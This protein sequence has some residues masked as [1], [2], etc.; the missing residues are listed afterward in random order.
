MRPDQNMKRALIAFVVFS[1]TVAVEG[2]PS[3]YLPRILYAAPGLELN[4][5]YGNVFDSVV[6]QSY[7]FQSFCE[8]GRA[9]TRRWCFTPTAADAGRQ[10]EL[11]VNAWNDTGL[12]AAAT[13]TVLVATLPS[14]ADRPMTMALL[15]DSLTNA[16]YQDHLFRVMRNAGY[17]SYR[18]I[19][20]RKSSAKDGVCYD[21]YGGYTFESFLTRY[22]LSEEEVNNI[23]DAAEREQ[24][25]TLGLSVKVVSERQRQLLRSPLVRIE[26][27]KKIVDVQRWLDRINGGRAPDIILIELG[28]NNV[29][30]FRGEADELHRRI[31]TEVLPQLD[32]LL[33][34]L[35]PKMPNA[36][37]LLS[38]LPVG[39][40][41]D[42]FG[43]NYGASWNEVQ[44]RKIMFALN[45]EFDGYVHASPA[46]WN[47]R[48]LP[49]GHAVDP[50]EGFV[51]ARRKPS[52]HSKSEAETNVNAVH[53][54]DVGGRQMG[55]AIAAMLMFMVSSASTV[56]KPYP[57][58]NAVVC[59][60]RAQDMV[61][62]ND[63]LGMRA[64]GPGEYHRWS[65]FDVFNKNC[66]SNVC[67]QWMR[68]RC[69][70][71]HD[72]TPNFHQ[73][74]G[75]GM[76]N[77]TMGAS[78]GV[79][80][81]ALF[82]D[83]E[84]KT[85]PNWESSRVL[86]V[87]PDYCEFEITYPA[88]S[89]AGRMTCHITLKRGERFFR[90]DVM[91]ERMPDDFIAGPGMDLE[92]RRDH[93]GSL[94]ESE[95]VVSLFEDPKGPGGI[96][97]S[98]MSA[99]FVAKDEKTEDLTDNLNCRVLGFRGRRSFTY[100][101]GAS[102]SLAGEILTAEQWHSHVL[103]TREKFSRQMRNPRFSCR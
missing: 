2:N 92:P 88:F 59:P 38:T 96:D 65:G 80:G 79:G 81:I 101:A 3:F 40:S 83:G 20:A 76:D 97:G 28:V 78:R 39:A 17:S 103:A 11:V 36:V 58:C 64:Y 6:P 10:Y 61:W 1:L 89:A 41:Q 71:R 37:F 44:H 29:F 63:K 55:D 93:K 42:A 23:Q 57:V 43:A 27:G 82:G 8:K 66:V 56:D 24:L 94:A 12:V 84:W 77:Y 7:A 34:T 18:P 72:V 21:G 47:L 70:N 60:E 19:G 69:F 13:S 30:D 98:T 49:L 14:S 87:G 46:S 9:E 25:R 73:N 51:R 52:A 99:L 26:D 22:A 31:R 4:V 48:L 33:A 90:N 100:W 53:L 86:H 32:K 67:I 16:G 35:R 95:G 5:Y 15:G 91:F 102:W 68:D 45:R 75:Q 54:S 74:L 50:V 62:E 85:Y